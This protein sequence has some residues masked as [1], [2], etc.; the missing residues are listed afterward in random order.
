MTPATTRAI[1]ALAVP[2]A[3]SVLLNNL[4]RVIDQFAVQWLG[5]EAQL[6]LI[7]I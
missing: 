7:H 4:Y 5:P 6:S 1:V 2:A 3:A